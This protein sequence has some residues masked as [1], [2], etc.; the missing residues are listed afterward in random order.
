MNNSGQ[1]R[2]ANFLRLVHPAAETRPLSEAKL[3]RFG[4]QNTLFAADHPSL[5][6]VVE[7]ETLVAQDFITLLSTSRPK[8]I[9]DVRR[10]PRFDIANLNRRFVFDFLRNS[11][12]QY[13]DLSGKL[14]SSGPSEA[15]L[16]AHQIK[17]IGEARRSFKGPLVFLVDRHQFNED[18]ILELLEE[19]PAA[20][21]GV[22][23]VLKLPVGPSAD[24]HSSARSLVFV[25]HANPQ[26]NNFAAWLAGKLALAGYNV[27]SDVT[28]LIGGELFFDDI[29]T[30]IR[31]H[32]AK[33]IVIL[34]RVSQTKHGVLDEIDLAIRVERSQNL[35]GF[36]IPIR[37]DDLP[38]SEVRANIARKH[39]IDFNRSWTSGLSTLLKALQEQHVPKTS[40]VSASALS[41]CLDGGLRVR[42][43][44]IQKSET[45][46]SN[47]LLVKRLPARI[48]LMDVDAPLD[49]ISTVASSVAS[50]TFVYLRLIGMIGD[51]G[52]GEM[53]LAAGR[54]LTTRYSIPMEDF[55][56]GATTDLPGMKRQ[57]AAIYLSSLVRQA[58]NARM[59]RAAFMSYE[60]ASNA[61][62]WFPSHGF[63]EGNKVA[64]IDDSGTLRRKQLVGWS[65]RRQVFGTQRSRQKW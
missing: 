46:V 56:S 34:S 23:D 7:L 49:E 44:A 21:N 15:R 24:A 41:Q 3:L 61:L 26:D 6:V 11:G 37:I 51:D 54:T 59:E 30:A 64:F 19:L 27:W 1:R 43:T 8:L 12:V 48:D 62:A 65:A 38:F 42:A 36:V 40:H 9:F 18:Y 31:D 58:W 16:V 20:P 32:A 57:E 4:W 60:M 63:A 47:W 45:L 13:V 55:L 53:L 28:K 33:F 52:R 14:G 25:S 29:E 22:W 10:V 39:I 17:S 35:D 5:L 2:K 50:P